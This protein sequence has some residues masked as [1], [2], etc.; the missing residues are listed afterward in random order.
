MPASL[1]PQS[2]AKSN[3]QGLGNSI[4]KFKLPFKLEEYV[5]NWDRQN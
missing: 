4:S 5:P 1:D 3:M 2:N